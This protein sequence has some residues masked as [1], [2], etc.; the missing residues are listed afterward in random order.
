MNNGTPHPADGL[1]AALAYE[2]AGLSV[3]PIRPDGSKAPALAGWKQCQDRR[4]TPEELRRLF[5]GRVGVAV[6]GGR[7]SGNLETIDFDR[8][9]STIFPAWCALVEAECPGLVD[10]LS[11]ARTPKPGYHVRYRCAEIEIPGN[12]KLAVDPSAPKS[13]QTLVETRGSGGYSLA[14]GCPPECHQTGRTYDHYSGPK[15]SQVQEITAAE[16]DVLIRCARSFDRAAA[17]PKGAAG[18]RPGDDFNRRGPDWLDPL[19]LGHQGWELARQSGEVRYLRRPGKGGPGWSATVGYCRSKDGVELLAVFSSNCPPFEIPAGKTCGCFSKFG[20]Y[21]LVHHGGNFKAASK[22]LRRQGYGSRSEAKNQAWSAD[23]SPAPTEPSPTEP[24]DTRPATSGHT[25]IRKYF[26]VKYQPTHRRGA[27]IWSE[28]L[29]REI[30]PGEALCGAPSELIVLL[31]QACDRPT[32]RDGTTDFQALPAFFRRWA[33]TAWADLAGSLKDEAE[34]GEIGDHAAEEFK[35]RLTGALLTLVS[36]GV[37]TRGRQTDPEHEV[38][39]RSLLDWAALWAKTGPWRR[40]RS[41]Q[42]WCRR[43]EVGHLA[44]C[45]RAEFF[46]QL[47]GCSLAGLGKRFAILAR[48]Y[49]LALPERARPQGCEAVELAPDYV[50]ELL[51]EPPDWRCGVE[52]QTHARA[53]V[54][55]EEIT[56]NVS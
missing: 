11:V 43:D 52:E 8:E 30:R 56:P 27:A 32:T 44:L 42:L 49:G 15:L 33:P 39:R 16:R 47:P 54:G 24:G 37:P 53:H 50:A 20:T 23:D 51:A 10:R 6:I 9:A 55:T 21:A 35:G 28:T 25:I 34:A 26:V 14:P 13:E 40:I 45:V 29:G 4:F 31:A 19:L 46:G 18:G 12:L 7:V 1:V 2:A 36:L 5:A 48:Q 38:Q 17:E 3:I 22:D 41:Y